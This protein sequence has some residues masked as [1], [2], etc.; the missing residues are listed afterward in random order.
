[1]SGNPILCQTCR[2]VGP[3]K[4]GSCLICEDLRSSDKLQKSSKDPANHYNRIYPDKSA[5]V[6]LNYTYNMAICDEPSNNNLVNGPI[7]DL[8][9]IDQLDEQKPCGPVKIPLLG[10]GPFAALQDAPVPQHKNSTKT[11]NPFSKHRT[12]PNH[13][14]RNRFGQVSKNV[15][16]V[17][18]SGTA[19][20]KKWNRQ[21][22]RNR[23]AQLERSLEQEQNDKLRK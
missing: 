15:A 12:P 23:I 3:L 2:E 13:Q 18:R 1:M 20:Q 8:H 7:L 19:V 21:K 9:H 16:Q 10:S 11:D 22:N 14:M 4:F 17:D 6:D 5:P